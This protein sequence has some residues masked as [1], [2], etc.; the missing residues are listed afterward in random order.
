MN[1]QLEF[2]KITPF[3]N[4]LPPQ[5]TFRPILRSIGQL[6]IKLP[7]KEII[8]TDDGRTDR[9]RVRQQLVVFFSE[10]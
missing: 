9:R 10:K 3:G 5:R 6:D 8:S 2:R 1:L 4:A 7:Q